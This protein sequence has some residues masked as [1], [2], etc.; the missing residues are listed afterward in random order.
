M[1]DLLFKNDVTFISLCRAECAVKR[2]C[3]KFYDLVPHEVL[4]WATANF[5][6]EKLLFYCLTRTSMQIC[7]CTRFLRLYKA[8]MACSIACFQAWG[9]CVPQKIRD[10]LSV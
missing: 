5:Q 6:Q 3:L 4:V 2:L 10:T 1:T 8:L 7:S 9:K